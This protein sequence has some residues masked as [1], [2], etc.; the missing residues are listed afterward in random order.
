MTLE[1]IIGALQSGLALALIFIGLRI[2]HRME[3]QAQQ[4]RRRVT[5]IAPVSIC[6]Q[7]I[8]EDGWIT[9]EYTVGEVK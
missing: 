7:T 5:R 4:E 9:A 8:S 1:W 3:Q 6:T 2:K